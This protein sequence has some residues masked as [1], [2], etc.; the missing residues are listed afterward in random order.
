MKQTS[1]R[2]GLSAG[3]LA[4]ILLVTA[5]WGFN[6]IVIK[7]GVQGV[8]PLLL[9]AFRFVLSSFPALLF[10]KKPDVSWG[11]LAAYGLLLG[12]GEFG[13]LFTAI[14]LG[15]PA[16]ESSIILQSQAFFTAILAA[17]VLKEKIRAHS[18]AGMTIAG[19]GLALIAWSGRGGTATAITFLPMA[20]V[21]VA[22]FFWAAAN[23]VAQR[24]PKTDGLSLVVWSS[25]FSPLP[26]FGLS[27]L[28]ERD[29]ILPALTALQPVSIGALAYLVILST[30]FGYGVWNQLIIKHGAKK[31]APFSLLVPVFGM[32]SGALVLHETFTPE[33]ALAA[34]LV[35]AGLAIH[36]FGGKLDRTRQAP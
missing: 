36:V 28:L 3:V 4:V 34:A 19:V 30:L 27:F 35:L 13:F 5:I 22:A 16:G 23:L 15:A 1:D 32:T 8:P 17:L 18:I 2:S 21:I 14:K 9:A 26:L 29:A 20:M 10:V 12:V 6:F 33:N 7:V 25:I 31:V 11:K 24:M